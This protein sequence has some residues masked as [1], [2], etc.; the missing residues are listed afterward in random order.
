MTLA[1][2]GAT[3]QLG[4][5]VIA[6]LKAKR[7]AGEIVA[8]A[9]SP[10]KAADLGVRVRE[11]DYD[12]PETLAA[13]LDGVDKLLLISGSEIGQRTAQHR[14]VIDA[15][16][17]AGVG[18][19]I[20]TSLLRA[21]TSPMSLAVEHRETEALIKA[22]GLTYTILRNGWYTENYTGSVAGAVQAG[23]LVG[24]AGDG[25]ISSAAR[26]DYAAAAVAVLTSGDHAGKTYELAGDS[27]YTLTDLAIEVSAQTGKTVPYQN[28]PQDEYSKI[29]VSVGLPEGFAAALASFDVD[30]SRGALF[31]DGKDLS[32]LI[33]RDTTPMSKSVSDALV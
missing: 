29:L 8:L 24:S 18:H 11:A 9:R 14:A 17:A 13:A 4:R 6:D 30:A 26:A 33:G 21:D 3:G 22:S 5:L 7:G 15:A 32:Q 25:R 31:H 20:Y 2:T 23:A 27:A 28:L 16:K 10:E 12:V 19:I 1:V